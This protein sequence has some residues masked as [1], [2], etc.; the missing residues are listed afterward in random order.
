MD[1]GIKR[2]DL[3]REQVLARQ[4][5]LR[6]QGENLG[7]EIAHA[8]RK[9]AEVDQQRAF[10]QRQAARGKITEQEFDSRMDE[11]EETRQYL[12]SEI[13]RLQE[14]RDNAADV[15]SGLDY[16]EQLLVALQGRLSEID[17]T[18]EEVRKLPAD[19]R[20]EVLMSR[21]EIVQTLCDRVIA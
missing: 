8:R 1:K 11:T 5:Q 16:T 17:L 3:I 18:P 14:L 2:P 7:G 4:A 19:K 15:Y 6:A 21:K 13:E 12:Q 10:F 9:L 20:I